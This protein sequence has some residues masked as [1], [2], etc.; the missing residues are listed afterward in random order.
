M[1]ENTYKEELLGLDLEAEAK[2]FSKLVTLRIRELRLQKKMSQI[3]LSEKIGMNP[4]YI[5]NLERKFINPGI[6]NIY[7]VAIGLDMSICELLDI[8][9]EVDSKDMAMIKLKHIIES[10]SDEQANEVVNIVES[11]A[12]SFNE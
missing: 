4:L 3:E 12:K 9:T 10:L 1:Q 8:D 7:K 5:S 2:E 11:I 6:K